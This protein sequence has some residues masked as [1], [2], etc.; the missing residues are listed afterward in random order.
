MKVQYEDV[1]SIYQ[2]DGNI[3]F[4]AGDWDIST[5]KS[6]DSPFVRTSFHMDGVI[7]PHNLVLPVVPSAGVSSWNSTVHLIEAETTPGLQIDL[8]GP[9]I[10]IDNAGFYASFT[11]LF[12]SA[13]TK[14]ALQSDGWFLEFDFS[15]W[16]QPETVKELDVVDESLSSEGHYIVKHFV[17][18]LAKKLGKARIKAE[19]NVKDAYILTGFSVSVSLIATASVRA[20]QLRPRL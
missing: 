9:K 3:T 13:N 4:N 7:K 12:G 18:K 14:S 11:I 5:S 1:H 2:Y 6:F 16:F 19:I 20:L 15:P 10:F 17:G 8:D